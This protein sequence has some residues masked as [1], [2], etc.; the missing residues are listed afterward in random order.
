MQRKLIQGIPFWVEGT[1]VHA[2]DP[3]DKITPLF[4]GTYNAEKDELL[5]R[6][7]WRKVYAPILAAFRQ[8]QA[9]RARKPVETA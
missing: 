8:S 5:L 6:P 4:L 2:Y 3:N 9:P 1:K 7:D